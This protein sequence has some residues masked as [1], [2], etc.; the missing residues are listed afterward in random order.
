MKLFESSLLPTRRL[1]ADGVEQI[2][3]LHAFRS[4][5]AR[6]SGG[7]DSQENGLRGKARGDANL[8]LPASAEQEE[9]W[10]AKDTKRRWSIGVYVGKLLGSR[11]LTASGSFKNSRARIRRCSGMR[12]CTVKR[13][14]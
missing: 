8:C 12:P 5:G 9:N 7:N 14:F 4:A 13:S 2:I 1:M 11:R 3:L 6:A 10:R